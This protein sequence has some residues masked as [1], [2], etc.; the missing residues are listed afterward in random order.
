[1]NGLINLGAGW[2]KEME[3]RSDDHVARVH[4]FAR[5]ALMASRDQATVVANV[6]PI[7]STVDV[8]LG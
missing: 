1:M 5:Q 4:G 8:E 7:T 3:I 6:T 2:K